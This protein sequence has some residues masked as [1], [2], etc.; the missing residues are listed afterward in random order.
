MV[1]ITTAID[2]EPLDFM[3]AELE[4]RLVQALDETLAFGVVMAK[5]KVPVDT[6]FLQ[7]SIYF[8][9]QRHNG[10]L[11]ATNEAAGKNPKA[12]FLPPPLTP[13][14]PWVGIIASG[15]SYSTLIEYGSF[16]TR[17]NTERI[18]SRAGRIGVRLKPGKI[19]TYSPGYYYMNDTGLELK[20]FFKARVEWAIKESLR[21]YRSKRTRAIN[22]AK[23][24]AA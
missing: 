13:D 24:A 21:V 22:R 8:V 5:G 6:G 2:L 3:L 9:S 7:D 19:A 14:D 20:P 4:K 1:K 18:G 12:R 17:G 23:A 15:A 11:A 10:F 16:H